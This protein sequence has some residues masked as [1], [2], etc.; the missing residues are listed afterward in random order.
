MK[1]IDELV[2]EPLFLP[3]A[4]LGKFAKAD[5]VVSEQEIACVEEI[6]R[7]IDLTGERRTKAI[8]VFDK[9]KNGSLTYEESLSIFAE[10]TKET[11]E[12]RANLCYLLLRLAHAGGP[13]SKQAI[14]GVQQACGICDLEFSEVETIF[15]AY[16]EEKDPAEKADHE[17]RWKGV[18]GMRGLK[19]ILERDV[20]NPLKKPKMYKAYG[21][22]LPNGILL[23]GPP[24]CGKTFIARAL[25]KELGR[26][27][28]E[29]TPGDLACIY[30]HGTQGKIKELFETARKQAPSML[31][32]DEMD[33]MVPR[34]EG[35]D[36]GHHYASEVN[37]FLVQLN[38]CAEKKILVVGATNRL[39]NIDEAVLR[40]GRMDKKFL[41]GLPDDEARIDLLKLCMANRKQEEI[42]WKTCAAR[43][44]GYTCAEVR[45][46]VNEAARG[47]LQHERPIITEDV[48]RAADSNPPSHADAMV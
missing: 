44:N 8:I 23:Y 1:E 47:A 40:P 18:A 41:V 11:P 15:R 39:E 22:D 28:I 31:F 36:V 12:L 37:E 35:R 3:I 46:V 20:I 42:E 38:E 45:H 30:V 2:A 43:L 16:Q 9:H 34:R 13:A 14:V 48:M 33:A 25:A 19:A 24:G 21:L 7:D 32:F 4:I 10:L 27:Y 29:V 17:V 26:N 5:G 6:L